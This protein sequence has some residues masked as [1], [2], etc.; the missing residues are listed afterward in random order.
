MVKKLRSLIALI[1]DKIYFI[2]LRLGFINTFE[3]NI[4]IKDRITHIQKFIAIRIFV[5][6]NYMNIV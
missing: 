4:L 5:K 3:L 6:E 2:M 1:K